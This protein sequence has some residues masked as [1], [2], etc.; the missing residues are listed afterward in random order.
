V[1]LAWEQLAH[2][3]KQ[4]IPTHAAIPKLLFFTLVGIFY[5]LNRVNRGETRAGVGSATNSTGS[6]GSGA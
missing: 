6:H 5:F 4:T 3:N 1:F 2:K